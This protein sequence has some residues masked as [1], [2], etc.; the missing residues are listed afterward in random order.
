V[1]AE[2]VVLAVASAI[3]PSTSLAALYA[4]LSAPRPVP[5][6]GA[7]VV[8]G[9]VST[10]LVGILVVAVF[11]GVTPSRRNSD[12]RG[13]VELIAGVA[14]LGVALGIRSGRMRGGRGRRP[15]GSDSAVVRSLREP[16]LRVAGSAGVLTHLPGLITLVALTAIADGSPQIERAVVAVLAY[17]LVWFSVPIAALVYSVRRPEAARELMG[18]ANA[19][20]VDHRRA[21]AMWFAAALG[22]YLTVKGAAGLLG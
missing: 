11:H 12:V 18:R 1:S 10:T 8:A 14:L 17:N 5:R 2:V 4:L 20:G 15:P 9:L 13:F 19:W 6:V 3:R 7:F 21:L 22:A 16:S